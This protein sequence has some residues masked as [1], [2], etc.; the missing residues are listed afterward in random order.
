[1]FVTLGFG[2]QLPFSGSSFH[3]LGSQ[4][5]GHKPKGTKE[6]SLNGGT[7]H[8]QN[9]LPSDLKSKACWSTDCRLGSFQ[10][11]E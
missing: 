5:Q 7:S 11:S 2:S 1:M 10:K 6:N 9:P 3:G 8:G 4:T